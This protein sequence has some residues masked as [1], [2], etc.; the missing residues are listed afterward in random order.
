MAGIGGV[1][2]GSF[3][4]IKI[5]SSFALARVGA[6]FSMP[7][8][9]D[10][11]HPISGF[12]FGIL[13]YAEGLKFP[14]LNCP[15][16]PIDNGVDSGW[17]T[18]ANFNAWFHTRSSGP[19]YDLS[20]ITG[21]VIFSDNGSVGTGTGVFKVTKVKGAGYTITCRKGQGIGVLL[22]FAGRTRTVGVSGDKP[23]APLQGIPLNFARL[24][25][26]STSP[27]YQKGIV[28]LTLQFDTGLTPNMEL[29][30]TVYPVEHNAGLPTGTLTLECNALD[31]VAAV[32]YDS[33]GDLPEE[34]DDAEFEILAVDSGTPVTVTWTLSKLII[35]NPDDRQTQAGRV[36]RTFQYDVIALYDTGVG[37]QCVRVA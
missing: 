20:E 11:P 19:V 8:N 12:G 23:T 5:G 3:G 10:M 29:D 2:L 33:T 24:D 1:T 15:C 17:F 18:A 34:V 4:F 14:T 37:Y 6:G 28:G 16:I 9:L 31:A 21:G 7:R 25:F 35:R 13:N 26:D 36:M 22:R 30:G 27:F 32:G